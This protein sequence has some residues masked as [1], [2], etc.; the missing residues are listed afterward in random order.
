MATGS[1]CLHCGESR[2]AVRASQRGKN[3]I[4]CAGDFD[5]EYGDPG[6]EMERHRF[7]DWSHEHLN[8]MKILPQFHHLYLR[9]Q[10]MYDIHP[11][12]LRRSPTQ[13]L[14]SFDYD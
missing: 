6:W 8:D 2:E 9:A 12:H 4:F 14:E 5:Y 1:H 13:I 11:D 7:R 3:P 10:N